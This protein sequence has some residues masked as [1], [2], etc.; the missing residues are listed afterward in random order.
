MPR[1]IKPKNKFRWMNFFAWFFFVG[2]GVGMGFTLYFGFVLA[3]PVQRMV[4]PPPSTLPVEEIRFTS[5]SGSQL[6]GWFL[7]GHPKRGG[8][9]L[10]HGV[11]ADRRSMLGRARFLYGHGYSVLLFDFQAHGESVGTHITFGF[12]EAFD[13]QAAVEYLKRRVGDGPVAVIGTSLGGAAALLCPQ[14]LPVQAFVIEA[15]YTDVETA[16][17]NRLSH[18]LGPI[19]PWLS[20]LLTAQ[21]HPRIGVDPS[22][23]RPIQAI[24]N[25][26]SPVLIVAGERD[27]RTTLTDSHRLYEATP[28]P[29]EMWIIPGAGHVDFH[30]YMPEEY[31][32][33]IKKFLDKHMSL[34]T[35]EMSQLPP[36]VL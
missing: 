25:I 6:K 8:V 3:K 15:V 1:T 23:L 17:E 30:R 19:G 10:M 20:P 16:V 34:Q 24:G 33:R 27:R 36:D 35:S 7:P 26:T 32:R 31:E 18:R 21:L 12:L 5:Q 2:L 28:E 4:G 22:Q 11:R 14:P 9:V 29:K 13:A